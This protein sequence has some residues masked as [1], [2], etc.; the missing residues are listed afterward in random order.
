MIRLTRDRRSMGAPASTRGTTELA[1]AIVCVIV[2]LNS[3][4]VWKALSA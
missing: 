2:A 1:A 3:G 4:L